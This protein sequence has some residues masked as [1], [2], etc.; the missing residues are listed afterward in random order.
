VH[1]TG[2]DAGTDRCL[3]VAAQAFTKEPGQLA[4]SKRDVREGRRRSDLPLPR[5]L[6]LRQ[7]GYTIA[8]RSNRLVDVLRFLEP[9]HFTA[10]LIESLRASQVDNSQ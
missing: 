9:H 3:A 8:K 7:A 2:V 4:V 10:G 1:Q 6:T 5:L